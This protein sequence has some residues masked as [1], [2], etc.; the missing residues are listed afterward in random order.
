[1]SVLEQF[2]QALQANRHWLY[3]FTDERNIGSIK[4]HGLVPTS[5][6]KRLGIAAVTG[7]DES[8]LSIDQH[9]GFDNFVRLSFCR[10][11]PMAHTAKEQGR[12]AN[13]RIL[14]V[15]PAVLLREGVLMAD[16]V[17]T[18]NEAVIGPPAELVPKMDFEAT[19]KRIDWKV[20]EN[21]E[22]RNA[23]EKWEAMIPGV[24]EPALVVGL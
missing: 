21:W 18:A 7:G 11:H 4:Q 16:R 15:P 14:L 3:H 9:R 6:L 17:A 24:I 8:S 2:V 10:K 13:V 22:R 12:I 20:P 23:A 5:E 1:M 19:Y